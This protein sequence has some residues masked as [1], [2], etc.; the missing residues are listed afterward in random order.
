MKKRTKFIA[1]LLAMGVLTSSIVP[2]NAN[3]ETIQ[4]CSKS[5]CFNK[6]E[7]EFTRLMYNS[8]NKH[9][10]T[11]CYGFNKTAINE[12]YTWAKGETTC[13]GGVKRGTAGV[14]Y[15]SGKSNWK[16]SKKEMQHTQNTV[17]Y[18]I[19]FKASYGKTTLGKEKASWN[20]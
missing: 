19:K 14:K 13:Y 6:D 3:A 9:I 11:L 1:Y 4:N 7:W 2:M 20:K 10:G 16:W 8:S 5:N 15:G 18:Y 17:G 12:D